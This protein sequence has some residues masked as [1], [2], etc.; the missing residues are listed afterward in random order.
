MTK[1]DKSL[2]SSTV[3]AHSPETNE[4]LLAVFQSKIY[5]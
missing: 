1:I 2:T 4:D 5:N 3:V